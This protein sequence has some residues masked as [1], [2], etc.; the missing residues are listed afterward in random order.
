MLLEARDEETGEGMNDE[1]LRDQVVTL[2]VAGFET[3]ANALNWTW[4]LL[5][6]NP[7]AMGTLQGEVGTALSAGMPGERTLP[8][9]PWTRMVVEEALRL[10]PPAWIL[11]RRAIS[12][13]RLGNRPLP[14]GSVVAISPYVLHRHPAFWEKPDMFEPSR[15]TPERI[16]ARH[17]FSYIP[18]GAGPR[19]CIGH[20]LAMMEAQLAVAT[21]ARD[22]SPRL[23][24]GVDV[25][26]E[27]RFTLRPKGGLP[28]TI[29]RN[30]W[31]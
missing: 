25:V 30:E 13:D 26:P 31:R 17:R 2:L 5:S 23:V 15:F 20:N 28:M 19:L 29:H 9:L 8:L 12:D 10:Y 3:T 14:A 27:R 1:Q 11:G 18:F 4:Y 6:E 7:E 21:L 24:P 22:F 16:A